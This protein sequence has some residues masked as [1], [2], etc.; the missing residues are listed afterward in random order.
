[1]QS[2]IYLVEGL[3]KGTWKFLGESFEWN[4]YICPD[5]SVRHKQAPSIL[6]KKSL[7]WA[8]KPT[9]YIS[10]KKVKGQIVYGEITKIT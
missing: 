10:V 6:K 9:H 8:L 3:K 7:Q 2:F 1:M 5:E 4:G